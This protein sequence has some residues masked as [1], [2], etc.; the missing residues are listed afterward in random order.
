MYLGSGSLPYTIAV[1][2]YGLILGAT[3][4]RGGSLWVPQRAT[5]SLW[6]GWPSYGRSSSGPRRALRLFPHACAKCSVRLRLYRPGHDP[7]EGRPDSDV[8]GLLGIQ[9][10]PSI[11]SL[12]PGHGR[13]EPGI[14]LHSY[15]SR[16]IESCRFICFGKQEEE[17]AIIRSSDE[18]GADVSRRRMV[19]TART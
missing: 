11:D 6:P 15:P 1:G 19:A 17:R 13:L 2:I 16:E 3:I 8:E 18:I 10:A 14:A 12:V 9:V 5:A 4:L 7:V